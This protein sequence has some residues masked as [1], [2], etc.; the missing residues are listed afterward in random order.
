M[1]TPLKGGLL[2]IPASLNGSHALVG[3]LDLVRGVLG[4]VPK[5]GRGAERGRTRENK[6]GWRSRCDD[7]TEGCLL[8]VAWATKLVHS[9]KLAPPEGTI[10]T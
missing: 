6:E 3:I 2:G 9:R 7:D 10:P 5:E 8:Q 1:C 4:K